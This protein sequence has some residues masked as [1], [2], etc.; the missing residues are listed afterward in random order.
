MLDLILYVAVIVVGVVLLEK[1]ET[2]R[3]RCGTYLI[4]HDRKQ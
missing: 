4:R 1:H 2:R 3:S